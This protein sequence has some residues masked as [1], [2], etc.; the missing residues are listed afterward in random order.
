MQQS[1]WPDP[2]QRESDD[3]AADTLVEISGQYNVAESER[4]EALFYG[5]YDLY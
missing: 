1:L 3:L 4:S 2:S 5:E